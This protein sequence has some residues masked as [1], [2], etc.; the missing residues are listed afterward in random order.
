MVGPDAIAELFRGYGEVGFETLEQ[1]PV[2]V[3]GERFALVHRVY[4]TTTGFELAMLA[5]VSA[6]HEGR[7]DRIVLFDS[8][9]LGAATAEFE[10]L[11]ATLQE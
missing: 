7:S 8:E 11:V 5:V 3:H 1:R 2:A 6:D 4:R 10:A 9:D